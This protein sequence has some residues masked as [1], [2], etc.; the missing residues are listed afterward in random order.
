MQ[1]LLT[2]FFF[3]LGTVVGSFLNVV[4]LR[5]NTGA[6]LDGRSRCFSC[7]K[8]IKWHDLAPVFSFIFL[9]GRCRHCKGKISFQYPLVEMLT[10]LIFAAT[11]WQFS[12]SVS[13]H[14]FSIFYFLFSINLLSLC[15]LLVIAVY[16]FRH[17]IIPDRLVFLFGFLSLVKLFLSAEFS[18]AARLP[19]LLDLLAGPILALPLFLLWLASSG[20]WIGLGDAKLAL[21]IGWF[22]GF[23]LG[24]SAVVLGF[25]VGAVVSLC[26]LAL[27]ALSR[28]GFARPAL[29]GGLKNLTMRSEVPLAPFLILGLM[30]VYFFGIDVVGLGALITM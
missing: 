18:T 27:P 4:I 21:G 1:I 5:F 25:G 19:H 22:L 7:G 2:L 8:D 10:G 9:K 13:L 12:S 14:T 17:K 3:A 30:A 15:L 16:D 20:R 28:A 29:R 6:G 24:I 23:S 26:L 11:F